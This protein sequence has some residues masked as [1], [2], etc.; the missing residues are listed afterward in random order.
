MAMKDEYTALINNKTWDLVPR[1]S[2]VNVIRSLWI[3]SNKKKSDGSFERYK[4]RL[5]GNGANQQSGID[6]GETFSPVVKPAIIRMVLSIELSKS[7]CLHQLDVKNA[8]LH[9]HLD[10]TIYMHQP[11]GFRDSQHPE[12]VC[13]LKNH[14]MVSNK[15]PVPDTKD[16]LTM[17]PHWV[18][19]QHL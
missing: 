1:P 3:F 15:H 18:A 11:L 17:F 2:N 8:F 19:T 13:L 16:S 7:W 4:A 9:G 12:H 14:F 10:E 5:V 6:F